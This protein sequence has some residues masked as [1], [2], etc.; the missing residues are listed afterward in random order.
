MD[1]GLAGLIAAETVLSHSDGARGILWVRGHTLPELVADFGYEGAVGLLWEGFAG[2]G[3]GRAWCMARRGG[4]PWRR[5]STLYSPA[6]A[7]TVSTRRP[8]PPGSSLR[9][10]PR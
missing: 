3:L 2:D 6:S 10:R 7:R 8:L 5:R 4:R 9:A 1:S